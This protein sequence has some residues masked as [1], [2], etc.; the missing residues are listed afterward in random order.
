MSAEPRLAAANGIHLAYDIS[1]RGEP[2]L[3]IAGTGMPRAA[4]AFLG[5]DVLVEAGYQVITFDSRGVGDSDGPPGPY[6][7]PQ[8]AADT[9]GVLEALGVDRARIVGLSLGGAVAQEIAA[10]RPDLVQALVL[11]ASA[12]RSPAFFRRLL[13]V[14]AE[15]AAAIPVPESWHLWQYLLISLPVRSLQND[16]SLVEAVAAVLADGVSW[17]GDGRAGQFAADVEWDTA[18]HSDL[19]PRITCPCLVVGHEHDLI[20]PPAAGRVAADA[21]PYGVFTEIPGLAHGQATQAAP[22]V[23]REAVEFFGRTAANA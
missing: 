18:D 5:E 22:T 4:W 16:D 2:I 21:M 19:Y 7:V 9:V 8:M 11:W 15:I 14:E 23:M 6:S 1:G 3:L 10:T 17:A 12:G 13:A 20:Y